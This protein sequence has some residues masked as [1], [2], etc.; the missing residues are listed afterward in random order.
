MNRSGGLVRPAG[1]L[2]IG[3]LVSVAVAARC[4]ISLVCLSDAAELGP[5]DTVTLVYRV[6]NE[7]AEPVNVRFELI[8]PAQWPSLFSVH[9]RFIMP[10]ENELVLCLLQ[11]P[12]GTPAG[13]YTV[14][15]MGTV[16]TAEDES[17]LCSTEVDVTRVEAFS[18]KA[19]TTTVSCAPDSAAEFTVQLTNVGN[20]S[21]DLVIESAGEQVATQ[22][23]PTTA[24]LEPGGQTEVAVRARVRQDALPGERDLVRIEVHV[25]GDP[26][27]R[28]T[29]ALET[30]A[31]PSMADAVR[32]GLGMP[33]VTRGAW[34]TEL[35]SNG[36]QSST[37]KLM[38]EGEIAGVH[39]L[40]RTALRSSD[41]G[42]QIAL[43]DMLIAVDC[44]DLSVDIGRIALSPEPAIDLA[45]WGCSLGLD[46]GAFAPHVAWMV[47]GTS[48]CLHG[49]L[50][51]EWTA[52]GVSAEVAWTRWA[53]VAD[54][55][56]HAL[57]SEL[58][59]APAEG[60]SVTGW[61]GVDLRGGGY[62][63]GSAVWQSDAFSSTG[64]LLWIKT[65]F[66]DDEED[67]LH[68][69]FEQMLML[70]QAEIEVNLTNDWTMPGGRQEADTLS[71]RLGVGISLPE[72]G[73]EWR[74]NADYV[75]T[76]RHAGLEAERSTQEMSSSLKWSVFDELSVC[77]SGG[78][79]WAREEKATGEEEYVSGR[80]SVEAQFSPIFLSVWGSAEANAVA[81]R[82]LETGAIEVVGCERLSL[83]SSRGRMRPSLL[84]E[85]THSGRTLMALECE[86]ALNALSL[87]LN[88][89]FALQQATITCGFEWEFPF[90]LPLP[91]VHGQLQGVAFDDANL[92]G[93]RDAGENALE[94]VL[95][96]L[97]GEQAITSRDGEYRFPPMPPGDYDLQLM[98]TP[99]GYVAVCDMPVSV[100]LESGQS[101]GLEIPLC[102]SGC[103]SG[104]VILSE[105]ESVLDGEAVGWGGTAGTPTSGIRFW[106]DDGREVITRWMEVPGSFEVCGLRPGGWTV[107]LDAET[108]PPY[109]TVSPQSVLINLEPG[110]ME[111]VSFELCPESRD[112]EWITI[113]EPL[114][115]D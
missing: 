8:Q 33:I 67:L 41:W 70:G 49:G 76:W 34:V 90:V 97:S 83:Q 35:S 1:V 6:G 111:H 42:A 3:L 109:T 88:H 30:I 69:I 80:F 36:N 56:F 43:T 110:V 98:T 101:S 96:A 5:S 77:V 55:P 71:G 61:S 14:D 91:L 58:A 44:E 10:G 82:D 68:G 15:L 4:D 25:A 93:I 24:N 113:P 89:D 86:V 74:L 45:G 99:P 40:G 12:I 95:L 52:S 23:L 26:W 100:S 38:A 85:L 87:V 102:I 60:W 21:V 108:L 112:I 22:I 64:S 53:L 20:V 115:A 103:I 29:V 72:P 62:L 104:E 63:G 39:T 84:V 65:P 66:L 37:F 51:M 27:H 47:R 17:A 92:N 79:S 7:G 105:V 81:V 9:E 18:V 11:A 54:E 48:T 31:L 2:I 28:E 107:G 73:G 94:G 13:A 59:W 57:S 75:S 19:R 32:T 114:T 106:M 46:A 16:M 78:V 50:E